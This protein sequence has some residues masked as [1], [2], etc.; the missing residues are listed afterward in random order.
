[1]SYLPGD[2][3]IGDDP[4]EKMTISTFDGLDLEIVNFIENTLGAY[5]PIIRYQYFT[6][7]IEHSYGTNVLASHFSWDDLWTAKFKFVGL[8]DIF[9]S[10][11]SFDNVGEIIEPALLDIFYDI[12]YETTW[13][14]SKSKV[15]KQLTKQQIEKGLDAIKSDFFSRKLPKLHGIAHKLLDMYETK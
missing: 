9:K 4:F 11:T 3:L 14:T 5:D 1:V 2:L 8:F 10:L 13:K 6:R 12:W 7:L 15:K